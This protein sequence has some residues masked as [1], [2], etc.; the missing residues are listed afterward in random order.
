MLKK[1]LRIAYDKLKN[2]RKEKY[3]PNYIR[4]KKQLGGCFSKT[5]IHPKIERFFISPLSFQIYILEAA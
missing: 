5:N 1:L 3:M 4:E 2:W